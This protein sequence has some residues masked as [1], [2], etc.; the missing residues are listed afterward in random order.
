[1]TIRMFCR[2]LAKKLTITQ[3]CS[4]LQAHIFSSSVILIDKA[5]FYSLQR[6]MLCACLRFDG[7]Y[8]RDTAREYHLKPMRAF[9]YW[10]I[11]RVNQVAI[12]CQL[13][14]DR[15]LTKSRWRVN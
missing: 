10:F 11:A 7:K 12:A 6:V 15:E 2:P 4:R 14:R 8:E 1:M 13:S 5:F 3:C 9:T